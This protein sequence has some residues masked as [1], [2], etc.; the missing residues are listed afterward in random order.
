M[1]L[2]KRTAYTLWIIA[3][4]VAGVVLLSGPT[5]A[6][7]YYSQDRIVNGNFLQYPTGW[8]DPNS[9][10]FVGHANVGANSTNDYIRQVFT[11]PLGATATL[12]FNSSAT[13]DFDCAEVGLCFS[14]GLNASGGTFY[15]DIYNTSGL[16]FERSCNVGNAYSD[17]PGNLTQDISNLSGQ[18]LMIVFGVYG[19]NGYRVWAR[20]SNVHVMVELPDTTPPTSQLSTDPLSANGSNGWFVSSPTVSLSASDDPG[21]SGLF[22]I[23]YYFDGDNLQIYN[24]PIV[25]PAGS[26]TVEYFSE[27]NIG[28]DEISRNYNA[29]VD[30]E[31]PTVSITKPSSPDG[32][33]GWYRT[34]LIIVAS[35]TD[36]T[37]GIAGYQYNV[38]GGAWQ[39]TSN[40]ISVP[41]GQHTINVRSLDVAGRIS[42]PTSVSYKTDSTAPTITLLGN[43]PLSVVVGSIYS[44]PGAKAKDNIDE[45]I[46]SNISVTSTVN[47]STPGSYSV[48]YSVTDAA[49][50]VAETKTRTVIVVAPAPVVVTP[51]PQVLGAIT[52]HP[53]IKTLKLTK[54]I[55]TY[56][57]NGKTIKISPFGTTYKGT[58]WARSVDFGPDGKIY[59]FINSGPYKKGQVKIYRADGKLLKAYNPYG[60][61]ATNGLNATAVI[62]SNDLVYLAV[63]TTKAGTTVKTYQVTAK[64]LKSLNSLKASNKSGNILVAFKKLYIDQYGLVTMKQGDRPTLKVWKLN[65]TTNKFVEDKKINKTKIKI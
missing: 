3:A 46:T 51:A 22:G 42:E 24:S 61:F 53:V 49:G 38:D 41:D 2:I 10:I 12:S 8:Y 65:L 5:K 57:L 43:N 56:K 13:T 32:N 54:G 11:I 63:A 4:T 47:P 30:L 18:S 25:I 14:T 27:D 28:N 16:V 33:N 48:T 29:K 17:C 58:V 60:G 50:N 45:D 15:V 40:N 35:G 52:F 39:N 1:I 6:K 62:E 55:Y 7:A 36:A 9:A 23:G 19:R 64:G 21:G 34:P 44:D 37:S 20:I 26:H 59:V 31:N